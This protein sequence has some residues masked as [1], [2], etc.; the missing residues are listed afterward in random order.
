MMLTKLN[1][2][3]YV[4]KII[5]FYMVLYVLKIKIFD[6]NPLHIRYVLTNEWR[7]RK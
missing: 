6:P 3:I 4:R 2:I 1:I 5:M 7:T